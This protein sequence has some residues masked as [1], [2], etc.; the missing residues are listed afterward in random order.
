M[1]C[2]QRGVHLKTKNRLYRVIQSVRGHLFTAGPGPQE[3]KSM[4]YMNPKRII[5]NSVKCLSVP[6][7]CCRFQ[8]EKVKIKHDVILK[9]RL[10]SKMMSIFV[11]V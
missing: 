11:G 4:F 5:E 3:I 1:H 6:L 9:V 10:F 7:S 2:V 8:S